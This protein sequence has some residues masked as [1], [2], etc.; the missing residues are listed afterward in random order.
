[1]NNYEHLTLMQ[2][3][4]WMRV[5]HL[6]MLTLW[7]CLKMFTHILRKLRDFS[8]F[9]FILVSLQDYSLSYRKDKVM[10]FYLIYCR[11]LPWWSMLFSA[12]LHCLKVLKLTF[13]LVVSQRTVAGYIVLI[14]YCSGGV[15]VCGGRIFTIF[16]SKKSFYWTQINQLHGM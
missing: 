11:Q 1:M 13:Y 8:S 7:F 16:H 15:C 6:V 9:Y 5:S 2:M 14:A 12:Y 4:Y 3:L 10:L